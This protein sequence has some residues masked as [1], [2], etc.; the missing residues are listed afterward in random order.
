MMYG[1]FPKV[2]PVLWSVTPALGWAMVGLTAAGIA[3]AWWARIALGKLWSGGV[4]R[5]ADHRV[6]E[7][8]PYRW[9]R[10]PIYT[11]LI[12]GAVALA[13]IQAKPWAMAG[14]VLFSLGFILKARVEERFLER[15]I[16]GY[17]DYRRR[18]SMILP[19][20]KFS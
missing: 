17:E 7:S 1:L 16:G 10:H 19:L 18:V 2:Q 12:A 11:G 6:V 14:A 3:F 13:V 15:E 5:M 9:V 20:P 4:E 8:G